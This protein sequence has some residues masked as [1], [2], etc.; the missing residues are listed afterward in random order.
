MGDWVSLSLSFSM[1]LPEIS[2]ARWLTSR[3]G[4]PEHITTHP[5][6]D[7]CHIQ[8]THPQKSHPSI[9]PDRG[10]VSH[11]LN[12]VQM[13]M[14][15][16]KCTS[17]VDTKHFSHWEV[18]CVSPFLKSGELHWPCWETED[19]KVTPCLLLDLGLR[20]TGAFYF[21]SLG[22]LALGPKPKSNNPETTVLG[23]SHVD[24]CS[25]QKSLLSP[26]F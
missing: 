19:G 23:Q 14:R 20:E 12:K 1:R 13:W 25:G 21:L 5:Q 6:N 11:D 7:F 3:A 4:V 26:A 10:T 17:K 9:T 15:L 24:R 16:L 8:N 18:G 22:T 2:L